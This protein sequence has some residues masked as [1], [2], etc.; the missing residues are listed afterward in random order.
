MRARPKPKSAPDLPINAQ[1]RSGLIETMLAR[2]DQ[3]YVLPEVVARL[4]KEFRLRLRRG[5]YD[6]ITSGRAMAGTLTKQLRASA[7][8]AHLGVRF[9]PEAMVASSGPAAPPSPEDRARFLRMAASGN[10]GF[11][12]V[13]RLNGNIGYMELNDSIDPDLGAPTA[14]AAMNFLANTDALIIDLRYNGGGVPGLAQL[15][16]TYF[17]DRPVHLHSIHWREGSRIQQ[18]WT[19][20]Y[21]PGPRYLGKKVY[22]LTSRHALSAPESFAYSLQALGLVTVV[23]ETTAG[24]ANPGREFRINDHFAI[25]IPTGRAVNR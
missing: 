12:R 22:L 3:H 17:F 18:Y 4:S 23:G 9:S 5:E 16:S 24:G 25:F 11:D 19:M 10:F 14:I 15:I 13:E 2:L 1:Q 6:Q 21:V 8:D 20:P 7:K